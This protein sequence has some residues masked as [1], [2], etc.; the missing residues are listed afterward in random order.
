[1]ANRLPSVVAWAATLWERPAITSGLVLGGQPAEPGQR[2]DR[3]VAQQR[4]RLP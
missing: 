2:G 4:E 1:M 3:P